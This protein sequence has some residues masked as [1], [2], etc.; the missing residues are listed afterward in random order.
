MAQTVIIGESPE[1]KRLVALAE[2][3]AATDVTVLI[4]GESG[5]GKEVFARFIHEKSRRANAPFIPINCG[6]IPESILESE[7]FGH[8]KGAFTGADRQRKGYFES[9][10]GGTIFLDE[11]GEMSLEV[12][13]KLLRVLE[14]GEFQ[15]V[16][17]SQTLRCDTRVIAA[18]NRRLEEEMAKKRFREDLYY[19]LRTV[20]LHIPPLR[21]RRG[22]ILLLTEKFV[23]DFER[24]H[25]LKFP[26]FTAEATELLLSYHYPG[27]VRE[28]RNIIE[29][30]IVL[31]RDGKI[32]AEKLMRRLQ[33]APETEAKPPLMLPA[34]VPAHRTL[35]EPSL[36]SHQEMIYRA[37][38]SLQADMA[39]LKSM[40]LTL[41]EKLQVQPP[42]E[43]LLL[44]DGA[45]GQWTNGTANG[46]DNSNNLREAL[47]SFYRSLAK[48][49]QIPSLEDLERYAIEE[50]LKRF[51]GNK[52]KTAEAL[53]ITERTLYRKL[54][55]YKL[56]R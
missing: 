7:L 6:A 8:E 51:S 13:V 54:N 27:N 24:K 39:E 20:E 30:L 38:M 56:S 19:R 41:I 48:D 4:T 44:P 18:T 34:V 36:A 25:G 40:L 42:K 2:Q 50:T 45:H 52:R 31:E 28:L 22:D 47:N 14:T 23:R 1:I 49:G 16:G 26:G 17:S 55:Q 32:T 46:K 12:Q 5:T 35:P 53:G 10:D 29:S 3:V 9:A 37:L 21:E 33:P 15:R 11:I 43:T